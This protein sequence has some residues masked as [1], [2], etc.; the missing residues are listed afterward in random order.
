MR[1]G[2]TIPTLTSIATLILALLALSPSSIEAVCPQW[3]VSGK[4]EIEQEN[5]TGHIELDL[6]QSGTEITGTAKYNG[7]PGKVNG[8]VV[9]DDFNV[10]ISDAA[11]KHVFSG[12]IGPGRIAGVNS[13]PGGS[14]PTVWYSTSAMKC[15]EAG[16]AT[17]S[18]APES[19]GPKSAGTATSPAQ[20]ATAAGK[21]F[22]NP[23]YPTVPAGKTEGTATL[24]WNGGPDHPN[25][26]VWV[27]IDDEDEKLVVKQAKGSQQVQVKPNK[28]YLYILKDS[29]QQLDS[30]TVT[31]VD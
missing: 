9:G 23:Q 6:K 7:A 28:I 2:Y 25:A 11:G 16:P 14:G 21:I 3:D 22:A 24:T 30:T 12:K 10:E 17:T 19:A 13:V 20:S 15:V 27:K 4:W 5:P 26:E 1:T 29:G 8:T 18:A 31:A